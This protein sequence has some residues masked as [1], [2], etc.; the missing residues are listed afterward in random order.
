ML[1]LRGE[2]C[3]LHERA[4]GRR[5]DERSIPPA[6]TPNLA[7]RREGHDEPEVLLEGPTMWVGRWRE[8][9][10][11]HLDDVGRPCKASRLHAYLEQAGIDSADLEFDARL[12][13][14]ADKVRDAAT[15]FGPSQKSA[16]NEWIKAVTAGTDAAAVSPGFRDNLL[17]QKITLF[18]E[19]TSGTDSNRM[20]R[21]L[22]LRC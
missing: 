5:G 18:G 20:G 10:D 19:C 14:A 17:T 9:A 2:P 21:P 8:R 7:L 11:I 3:L 15:R 12:Q 16:A 1:A 22:L 6:A 4:R 13:K